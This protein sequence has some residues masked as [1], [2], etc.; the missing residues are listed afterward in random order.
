MRVATWNVNSIR[1]RMERVVEWVDAKRPDVLCLQEIKCLDEQFPRETFEDMGYRVATFGQ[2]TYNGVAILAKQNIEDVVR[3]L[4]GEAPDAQKR[5]IGAQVGDVLLLNL[6]VVNGQEVGSP[7]YAYKME[8]MAR[9]AEFVRERY[10][11]REK[12]V[13][14]GDFNVT[15]DDR[16]VQL[17]DAW[18]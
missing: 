12:V 13:L 16:D 5:V 2:K 1:A 17:P 9:V 8:W 15:F 10:D 11:M 3:G 7:K 6:Y 18:R 14:C 4:P